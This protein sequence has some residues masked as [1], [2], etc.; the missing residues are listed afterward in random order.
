MS[1]VLGRPEGERKTPKITLALKDL[2]GAHST[3]YLLHLGQEQM[4]RLPATPRSTL[5]EFAG[6]SPGMGDDA[7]ASRSAVDRADRV[8]SFVD[9]ACLVMRLSRTLHALTVPHGQ[10]AL[11]V[12]FL[13]YCNVLPHAQEYSLE[14]QEIV[15][16]CA[17]IAQRAF[18]LDLNYEWYLNEYGTY[19][20]SLAADHVGLVDGRMQVDFG[21][22]VGL[23]EAP[24][25]RRLMEEIPA[26]VI[27]PETRF[28]AGRLATLVS[29][30]SIR[31]LSLAST[32]VHEKGSCP[33]GELL[34]LA[35]RINADYDKRLGR[36]VMA[37]LESSRP[38]AWEAPPAGG[39]AWRPRPWRT[40]LRP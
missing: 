25:Y 8:V 3:P 34:D 10:L 35:S 2:R 40:R 31:W 16:K 5:R 7:A 26:R 19:S 36:R 30:K 6:G 23:D 24:G 39:Q 33:D 9:A 38:P 32:I 18:G 22:F 37:D 20:P 11:F 15:Q 28:E 29:G 27:V 12:G 1:A 21:A 4:A 17:F 14:E 13:R